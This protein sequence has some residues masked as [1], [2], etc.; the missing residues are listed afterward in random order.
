MSE[1]RPVINFMLITGHQ[2]INS[3]CNLIDNN[4]QDIQHTADSMKFCCF[5]DQFSTAPI[6]PD[7]YPDL[8]GGGSG[9]VGELTI[10]W[11]VGSSFAKKIE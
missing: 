4:Q 10:T 9:K 2:I 8:I 5:S 6:K 7:L 1:K 3:E 11:K